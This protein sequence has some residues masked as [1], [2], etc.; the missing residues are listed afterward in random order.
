MPTTPTE[1]SD[2]EP[3][4]HTE[5]ESAEPTDEPIE[6]TDEQTGPTNISVNNRPQSRPSKKKADS[7]VSDVL[8]SVQNHFKRPA[9]KEDRY[10][11]F[12]KS[13]AIK[14]REL[15]K[16]QRLIAEKIINDT[17][18]EAELGNLT[19]AHKLCNDNHSQQLTFAQQSQYSHSPINWSMS[20]SSSNHTYIPSSSIPSVS[21]TNSTPP[22]VITQMQPLEIQEQEPNPVQLSIP[23][24][25]AATYLSNFQM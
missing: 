18:F 8:L 20:S 1:S 21:P 6:S 2:T 10:D 3:T 24:V 22:T 19:F 16:T 15:S 17:L 12:A 11:V 5:T 13:V 23:D 25:N 14:M 9:I 7:I 4:E